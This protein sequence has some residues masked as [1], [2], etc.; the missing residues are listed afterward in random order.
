M[1]KIGDDLST[2]DGT[3]KEKI[4]TRRLSERKE[5][6]FPFHP[7]REEEERKSEA[8]P[9]LLTFTRKS[10]AGTNKFIRPSRTFQEEK[11]EEKN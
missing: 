4:S 7:G 8:N 1:K 6:T 9:F 11:E 3:G 10:V 5:P 2:S